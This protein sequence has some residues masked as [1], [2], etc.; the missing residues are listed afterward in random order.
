MKLVI[1][2]ASGYI[3]AH[4]ARLARK[5]GYQ[6]LAASRRQPAMADLPWIPF[7]LTSTVPI[8][9]PKGTDAI[10]HL[11]ALTASAHH[12]GA[13]QELLAA[14]ALLAAS[15]K[16]SAKF[17]FVSSQTARPDAPTSYGR[18]KW[19]IEREV[20]EGGAW[21][22][23][24]GQVYGGEE[25][26]LFGVIV[27]TV[28]LLP[29]LPAFLPAPSIQP[30]HVDDLSAALLRIAE[31][32][33]IPS[34]VFCLGSPH[35]VTFTA[36]LAA[37]AKR[38]IRRLRCFFPMPTA[39][40]SLFSVL[41]ANS[42]QVRLG[43]GRLRSLIE[44]PYMETEADLQRLGLSLRSL[45]SG[46]HPSGDDKRR[47]LLLE[48]GALCS[49]L[50]KASPG[51]GVRRRYVRAIEQLRGGKPLD[52]P[53]ISL[54]LP[55][56]LALLDGRGEPIG[57]RWEELD[58]RFDTALRLV[59]A[60]PQGAIRFLGKVQGRGLVMSGL[61]IM[62]ILIGEMFWRVLRFFIKPLLSSTMHAIESKK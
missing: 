53:R 58:W 19:R 36:F 5:R 43:F 39:L 55:I 16:V 61:Q 45:D 40:I 29:I 52:L 56:S 62:R 49:Y 38:R 54:M 4:V 31:S 27:R 10:I 3:G 18:N 2:G 7:D 47:R 33:D 1:T 9:L 44:L 8:E 60:T 20:L 50:M 26:G 51:I 42:W 14:Q 15:K 24:P 23:R 17:I 46:M 34:G 41:A 59:E 57:R 11:A 21:V 13:E 28:R 35:P 48:G 32:S 6:V 37:I 30:I 22:A 25:K 12:I